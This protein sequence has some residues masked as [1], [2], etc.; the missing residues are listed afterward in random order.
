MPVQVRNWKSR[1]AAILACLLLTAVFSI[2][3]AAETHGAMDHLQ[4]RASFGV[5]D[6]PEAPYHAHQSM[7]RFAPGAVAPLHYHG[8]PGYI[9]ILEGSVT[10]YE[11][12]EPTIYNAGDSLVET[13][14]KLYRGINHTDEDML[15]MV[16][17][18]VPHG[19]DMTTMVDDP[20][21]PDAPEITP[22]VIVEAM[23]DLSDP[24]ASF[25]LVH[26]TMSHP[27][28]ITEEP[29]TTSGNRMM[30]VVDGQI[31]LSMD[32]EL[33][34]M[35]VGDSVLITAGTE[36]QVGNT[37]DTRAFTMS[38]SIVPDVH[39]LAPATGSTVD[40]TFAMWLIVMVASTLFVTGT[41]L[42][43]TTVRTR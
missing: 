10:L 29:A 39:S 12:G 6:P 36:Y 34:T 14:D 18:L 8:G 3:V 13:S 7:L 26:T 9:T 40:R 23:H 31:D 25:E 28:G 37:S 35:S 4:I 11:D 41:M 32:G 5:S 19:V 20:D 22:E 24:P 38:T 15:L 43:L 42:R 1:F 17:Y 33:Q 16:T 21:H 2:P 30:T 27:A